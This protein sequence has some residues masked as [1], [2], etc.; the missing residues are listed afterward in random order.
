MSDLDLR[1]LERAAARG[2]PEARGALERAQ[3]RA[4]LL[5]LTRRWLTV[6][7]RRKGPEIVHL[8]RLEPGPAT[9]Q[10]SITGRLLDARRGARLTVSSRCGALRNRYVREGFVTV[11]GPV[12]VT[13]ELRIRWSAATS[14]GGWGLCERCYQSHRKLCRKPEW[15][16]GGWH[17]EWA[18]LCDQA[19]RIGFPYPFSTS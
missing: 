18:D 5:D 7:L 11:V 19:A 12:A 6:S 14:E 13:N 17:V 2:D 9:H 4:G 10:S 8:A 15:K 16:I 3:E 1:L